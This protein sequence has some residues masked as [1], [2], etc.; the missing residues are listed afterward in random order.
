MNYHWRVLGVSTFVWAF[1][2]TVSEMSGA[3]PVA[4]ALPAET[5]S[6]ASVDILHDMEVRYGF[7]FVG[8]PLPSW[9]VVDIPERASA[10]MALLRLRGALERNPNVTISVREGLSPKAAAEAQKAVDALAKLSG[11]RVEEIRDSNDPKLFQIIANEPDRRSIPVH[12][13]NDPK[14]VALNDDL[15]TQ[16]IPFKNAYVGT[17]MADLRPMITEGPPPTV[18]G[19]H[20]CVLVTDTSA[21]V[22]RLMEIIEN[23]ENSSL[24]ISLKNL[25]AE[26]VAGT[27]SLRHSPG[28]RGATPV[29]EQLHFHSD[30]QTNR[31]FIEGP[32]EQLKAL[33]AEIIA[34]D[35]AAVPANSSK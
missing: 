8:D 17:L 35:K 19:A 21:K 13:G 18:S 24:A 27:Y 10:D 20:S 6:S 11:V 12:F 33:G 25:K 15:I 14:A 31:V 2:L 22:H 26:D 29:A 1:G 7:L 28:P 4:E 32:P 30:A 34:L 9:A 3:V 23:I 16:I 5:K